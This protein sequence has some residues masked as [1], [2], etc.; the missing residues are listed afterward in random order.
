M[1]E[2]QIYYRQCFS[3]LSG[4]KVLTDMLMQSGY[5]DADLTTEGEIAVRNF[6]V[7]ILYKMGVYNTADLEQQQRFVDKLFDIPL[8]R[9]EKGQD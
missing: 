3:T 9:E 6:M 1:S 5:F 8:I 7:S 2:Q 4:R